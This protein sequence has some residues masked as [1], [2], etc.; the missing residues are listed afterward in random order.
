MSKFVFANSAAASARLLTRIIVWAVI[1][2]REAA[3]SRSIWLSR[4][5]AMQEEHV[6][7]I[8]KRVVFPRL[9]YLYQMT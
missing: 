3:R 7:V 2:R 5:Y 9:W 1:M 6:V 4:R 8:V